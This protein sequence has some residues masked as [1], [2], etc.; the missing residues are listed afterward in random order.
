MSENPPVKK[1]PFAEA[2]A[3]KEFMPEAI[4]ILLKE[5]NKRQEKYISDEN[6]QVFD[7]GGGWTY[8]QER[9]EGYI[10]QSAELQLQQHK[11]QFHVDRVLEQD[12]N[13]LPD[14]YRNMSDQF[15]EHIQ[16]SMIRVMTEAAE[17][18]GNSISVGPND[19]AADAFLEMVKVTQVSVGADGKVSTPSLLSSSP[20]FEA[21]LFKEVAE[22]GK[23]FE[24]QV[25]AAKA[26]QAEDAHARE[27]IRL[28]KFGDE[29]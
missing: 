25:E 22:R 16:K 3:T 14:L 7:H 4:K 6:I 18:T 19:S 11:M 10:P 15:E 20:E 26:K 29:A 17:Q 27:K 9:R 1:L 12:L 8:Q 23:E 21:K 2:K 13:L 24:L 28:A 5:L